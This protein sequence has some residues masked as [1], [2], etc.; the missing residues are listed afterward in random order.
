M[1]RT[2]L[3]ALVL[4]GC[5]ARSGLD[6]G[7][8]DPPVDA[9]RR[10]APPPRD[11]PVPRDAGVVCPPPSPFGFAVEAAGEIRLD[12]PHGAI[13]LGGD[14]NVVYLASELL[15]RDELIVAVH[16][17]DARGR[18]DEDFGSALFSRVHTPRVAVEGGTARLLAIEAP[19]DSLRLV[20]IEEGI[21]TTSSVLRGPLRTLDRPAWNGSLVVVAAQNGFEVVFG[22]FTEGRPIA[23]WR[24]FGPAADVHAAV[25]PTTGESDLFLR[26]GAGALRVE[27]YARDGTPLVMGGTTLEDIGFVGP[28]AFGFLDDGTAQPWVVAGI[29]ADVD[30]P[31]ATLRRFRTDGSAAGGF[32]APIRGGMPGGVDLTTTPP[33]GHRSGYG[34]V[35]GVA[36]GGAIFHG[37]GEDFVGDARTVP[38]PCEG[39]DVSIASG[40]CGYVIACVAG[41]VIHTALAIP[42]LPR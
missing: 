32:S 8:E 18:D 21:V 2:L 41:G 37:A 16:R 35:A 22:P 4:V 19:G 1:S 17:L 24:S 3:F 38:I 33:R 25:H 39:T 11:A 9:G 34:M 28:L 40:P 23:T 36:L 12:A 5:G 26:D 6:L 31:R 42:P 14:G 10:D 7:L 15:A 20:S 13:S 29:T 27:S 30:G